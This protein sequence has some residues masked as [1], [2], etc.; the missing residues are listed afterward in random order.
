LVLRAS[1]TFR[2]LQTE[3]YYAQVAHTAYDLY[4]QRGGEHGRDLVVRNTLGREILPEDG[5]GRN[6]HQR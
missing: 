5:P 2:M 3:E 6:G 1:Y 4:Q